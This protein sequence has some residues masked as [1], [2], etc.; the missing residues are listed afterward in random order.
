MV[1]C[2]EKL[3]YVIR[4]PKDFS[5]IMVSFMKQKNITL[6]YRE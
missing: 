1:N 3:K 2:F 4:Y 5:E 6:M